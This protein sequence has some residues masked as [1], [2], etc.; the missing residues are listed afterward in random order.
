MK[1][2]TEVTQFIL[3][4]QWSPSILETHSAHTCQWGTDIQNLIFLCFF[5]FIETASYCPNLVF[6][7]LAGGDE[8]VASSIQIFFF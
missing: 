7:I 2:N 5:S 3:V 6:Q 1:Q 4:E 8:N